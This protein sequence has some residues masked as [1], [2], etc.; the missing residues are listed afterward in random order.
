ISEVGPG[1]GIIAGG[2]PSQAAAM[3]ALGVRTWLHV[4][5]PGLLG[6]FLEQGARRFILEGRECGGHVGPRSSFALWQSAI[7]VLGALDAETAGEVRLLFA[8]GIHDAFSAA[9]VETLAAGLVERGVRIG[10]LIGTAYLFTPEAVETGA[11]SPVFQD[12][13]VACRETALLTSGLGHA[14][15][16]A[17]TPFVRD[18]EAR[19]AALL[20]GELDPEQVR[21]ELEMLNVGRLRLAAKARTR[22]PGREGA[23]G[24]LVGVDEATQR[25]EGLFMLGEVAA[26][27]DGRQSMAALHDA[28]SRGSTTETHAR[29][30][31]VLARVPRPVSEAGEPIA[32]VG[33]ACIFPEADDLRAYWENIVL[34]VDAVRDVP[35]DR[36]RT[37]LHYDRDRRAKDRLYARR[38]AF[39]SPQRFDPV[40]YGIPPA[41]VGQIEAAQLLALEVA[42]R[43]IADAGFDARPFPR[44]RTSVIFGSSG[45]HDLGI[46]YAHRTMVREFLARADELDAGTCKRVVDALA[47]ML[48]EWTEDSFPGVLPNVITGRIANRLDLRGANFVVDAACSASLAAVAVAVGQLRNRSCDVAVAGAV[49]CSNNAFTFMGFAKTQALT[50][51]DHPRPFDARADG[52]VLG[53]GVGAVVLKRLCDAER[54]GDDIRA[55]IRGVGFSSDGRGRSLTAP[56]VEGQMLAL[57]RAYEDARLDPSGVELVEAHA[58]GTT[59][60]DT[61]EIEALRRVFGRGDARCALGSVKSQIGHA[62]T[63]AGMA[64]LIKTALALETGVLP[65]TLHVEEPNARLLEEGCP[66]YV[67]TACRPWIRRRPDKP[68]RAGVSAFGFGGTDFH[69]VLESWDG[70]YLEDTRP[71]LAPRPAEIF[72]WRRPTREA[73]AEDLRALGAALEGV[74]TAR[75]DA[76]AAAVFR[77]ERA[78]EAE[79][80][81][82][83]GVRLA[84]V[85][86][87]REDLDQKLDRAL[88]LLAGDE[89][90]LDALGLYLSDAAPRRPE[91]VAFL[92]PGQ[93]AQHPGMLADLVALGPFGPA[94]FETADRLL[95]DHLERPLSTY[96]F[97]PPP[98]DENARKA[99]AKALEDTRVAQPAVGAIELF[100]IDVL[101]RFGLAPAAAAGHSYG[102]YTALCA[103]GVYSR[104]DLLVLSAKRGR[105]VHRVAHGGTGGMLAGAGVGQVS[106]LAVLLLAV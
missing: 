40:A 16:C 50:P 3:E 43:A 46:A 36:W 76:L 1:F 20:A 69:L 52:I 74:A 61:A 6:A 100:A 87:T 98:P 81:A 54:D 68:R 63:A 80:P 11:I 88:A 13:A 55:V 93:G 104:E 34:G 84:I 72:A 14:T 22:S 33:M 83:G 67:N 60:G 29:S 95:A 59:V 75:L 73:L 41:I 18:F 97:P 62:K 45:I 78:R 92:F 70:A 21:I 26:L 9:M 44:E 56:R 39:L 105:A 25:R 17:K 101:A 86:S 65:P 15:R 48:P 37:E 24:D 64:G 51:G 103:A 30:A 90:R 5:S 91:E 66:F 85:A 7:G 38:G 82:D 28:V 106:E 31:R 57:E 99:Q 42:K 47:R 4:P 2:R 12:E 23:R 27:R 53:E 89:N 96:V 77:A 8:G 79:T 49:D 19:R 102:E 32:I 35:A 10:V 94:L 58:T 71:D